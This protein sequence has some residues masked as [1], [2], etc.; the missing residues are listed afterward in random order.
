MHAHALTV[1]LAFGLVAA[2]LPVAAQDPPAPPARQLD[3]AFDPDGRVTLRAQNVAVRDVLAEWARQCGCFVINA[4]GLTARVELPMQFDHAPQAQVLDALLRQAAG[5]VLT[6]RRQ[7]SAGPSRYETIYVLA[8][9]TPS[10]AQTYVPPPPIFTPMPPPTTGAPEDEIPP[11]TP[12]ATLPDPSSPP[13][14]EETEAP[15]APPAPAP[16]PAG[17]PGRFVPIVPIGPGSSGP[18]TTPGGVTPAPNS[19]PVAPQTQDD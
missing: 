1:L 4:Q 16:R 6:P 15:P 18:R 3:L 7:G 8:T 14:S 11:V 17:T 5:Y 12:I 10:A 9:S 19:G 13:V 2:S